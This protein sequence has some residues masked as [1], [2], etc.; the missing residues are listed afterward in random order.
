[1]G[2]PEYSPTADH[3]QTHNL[4]LRS[5]DQSVIFPW[6]EPQNQTRNPRIMASRLQQLLWGHAFLDP[7]PSGLFGADSIL[8]SR[9][10]NVVRGTGIRVQEGVW[11]TIGGREALTIHQLNIGPQRLVRHQC[12]GNA[13][14]CEGIRPG[15]L[16]NANR[17]QVSQNASCRSRQSLVI[18]RRTFPITFTPEQNL[19]SFRG[20]ILAFWLICSTCT[21]PSSPAARRSGMRRSAAIYNDRD[22]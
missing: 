8:P 20:S 17:T 9:L 4:Q 7:L 13:I 11:Q 16:K 18:T 21:P 2:C 3:G 19:H 10:C 14:V 22:S 5:R 6:W 12:C 1:M 15:L